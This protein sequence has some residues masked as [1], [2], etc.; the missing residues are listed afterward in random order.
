[1]GKSYEQELHNKRLNAPTRA[2]LCCCRSI[3]ILIHSTPTTIRA[4]GGRGRPLT[5][6][7][8]ELVSIEPVDTSFPMQEVK[9]RQNAPNQVTFATKT[10]GD[11]S[12]YLIRL[13]NVQRSTTL[14]FNIDENAETGGAPPFYRP[15]K[16]V[17]ADSFSLAL[18]DF[19]EG[20]LT[21]T[22]T[23]DGY[24]DTTTLRRVITDGAREVEFEFTDTGLRHG[25]YYFVRVVQ[26]NDAIAWSSPVWIGGHA[27]R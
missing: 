13:N 7:N 20:S 27:T 8:A 22:Q 6:N 24:Q 12:S 5:V 14:Q 15:A 2:K 11:T 26:A 17:P 4:A 9:G 3:P 19:A 18:K 16:R 25:D 1:M 21:H 23:F 10:R